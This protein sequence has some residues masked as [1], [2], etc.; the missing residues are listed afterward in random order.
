M[1]KVF[2]LRSFYEGRTNLNR[3]GTSYA[4]EWNKGA[5]FLSVLLVLLRIFCN[6]MQVATGTYRV[7]KTVCE[8]LADRGYTLPVES[9]IHSFDDFVE[10]FCLKSTSGVISTVTKKAMHIFCEKTADRDAITV[11]FCEDAK[12][13]SASLKEL[14]GI[15]GAREVKSMII[16]Y[17]ESVSPIAKRGVRQLNNASGFNIEL[18]FEGDLMHNVTKHT[19]VPQHIPLS[20]D[21]KKEMLRTFK[22]RDAQLPRISVND[23]VARYFGLAR[24]RVF[25]IVRPSETAGEYITYR[26]VV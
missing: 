20:H 12:V 18:F 4:L 7:Y 16:I 24:G 13:S 23:P 19:L 3:V 11:M 9:S 14:V 26:L 22:L 17:S 6:T 5:Y 15:A 2:I 21:E 10:R 1:Q 25:K 8:M